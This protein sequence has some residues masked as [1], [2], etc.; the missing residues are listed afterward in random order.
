M[1][2][3]TV[4]LIGGLATLVSSTP[5]S[6]YGAPGVCPAAETVTVTEYT[7]PQGT[8]GPGQYNPDTSGQYNPD[9]PVQHSY[10]DITVTVTE[11][12]PPV[13]ITNAVTITKIVPYAGQDATVTSPGA[14]YTAPP[15]PPSHPDTSA[16]YSN[17][18]STAYGARQTHRVE[19]G[20]FNGEVQFVPNSVEAEIGDVVEYDFLIKS[21]SLTQSEFL[22]P[23]TFNGGFD[24]GLNQPNP[25]NE[26]GLFVIPFEV[27]TKKPQWFYCKQAGPPKSHC[28]R[29][30]VFGLNPQDKMDQFIQNAINQD[31]NP[32]GTASSAASYETVKP[33]Y[34]SATATAT[35]A[36]A[37][38]TVGLQ[39]GTVL[40]FDPPYLPKV[41]AGQTIHF[42]FR[43]VNHTLTESS[44]ENPCKKL[45]G[46]AID[47]NF[48]NVNKGDIPEFKPFDL[49]VD[50]DKPRFF[51]CK[52]AN[53]TPKGHCSKGMVFSINTDAAT[54]GQFEANAL[55][56]LPKIKGRFAA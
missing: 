48:Q 39:N 5:E 29:G 36:V 33:T 18:T 17:T 20:T 40:K 44:L 52:Q 47:T 12:A 19:V 14:T 45:D 1:K 49:T 35:G 53:G 30:M 38:V 37:T 22:T 10:A 51:Y 34:T 4:G 21:H 16:V 43:A 11:T 9:N 6:Y 56:T 8:N 55:A 2:S 31:L 28:N 26:S 13:T 7:P 23:C 25:K 24:T 41:A 15:P 32:T 3:Y 46:T 50:S 42:D 54:F 27:T